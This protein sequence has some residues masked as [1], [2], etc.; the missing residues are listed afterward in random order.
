MVKI[1]LVGYNSRPFLVSAISMASPLPPLGS[2]GRSSPAVVDPTTRTVRLI[3][4]CRRAWGKDLREG[5]AIIDEMVDT[6]TQMKG[7][8]EGFS[9]RLQDLCDRLDRVLDSMQDQVDALSGLEE[10]LDAATKL[11]RLKETTSDVIYPTEEMAKA[12][13]VLGRSLEQQLKVMIEN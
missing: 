4:S 13:S 10:K 9:Y 6:R 8:K 5:K 1:H 11:K 3:L 7:E 2:A 12:V